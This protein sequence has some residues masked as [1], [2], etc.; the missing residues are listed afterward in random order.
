MKS[1]VLFSE[2]QKFKQWWIWLILIGIDVLILIGIYQQ[3]Y[4][5]HPFSDNPISDNG[6]LIMF[7][8]LLLFNLLFISLK[9]ETQIKSDGVYVRFFPFHIRYR[10]HEWNQIEKM[11]LRDYSPIREYGG[12][13]IRGFAKNRAL[14][15]S[16]KTGLQI[17]FVNG[18]KL[19][20]G[21][22]KAD[23]MS[24]LLDKLN[25]LKQ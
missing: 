1:D 11:Y 20:I 18:S 22:Q 19:L 10:K 24:V 8:T 6:L 4:K 23:E 16:G 14:N 13:G 15:I 7:G 3:I 9:L 2:S 17:E 12:W 5:G 25:R 21:T